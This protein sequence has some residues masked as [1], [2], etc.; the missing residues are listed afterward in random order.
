MGERENGGVAAILAGKVGSAHGWVNSKAGCE[1]R[2]ITFC[3]KINDSVIQAK[4]RI[5]QFHIGIAEFT[6]TN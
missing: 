6:D 1:Y 5:H 3:D 2:Y 4:P